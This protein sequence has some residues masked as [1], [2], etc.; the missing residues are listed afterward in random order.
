MVEW[1]GLRLEVK[2]GIRERQGARQVLRRKGHQTRSDPAGSSATRTRESAVIVEMAKAR[3]S[4]PTQQSPCRTLGHSAARP[5]RH[6]RISPSLPSSGSTWSGPPGSSY[7]RFEGEE[8]G[9]KKRSDGQMPGR[10][11]QQPDPRG[12]PTAPAVPRGP[13]QVSTAASESHQSQA[14]QRSL[15]SGNMNLSSCMLAGFGES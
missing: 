6:S 14:V 3:L 10:A 11:R 8:P 12:Q 1:K 2:V 9:K 15:C 7:L 5:R 13:F 4:P